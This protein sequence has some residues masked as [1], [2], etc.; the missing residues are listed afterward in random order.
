MR[1]PYEAMTRRKRRIAEVARNGARIVDRKWRRKSRPWRVDG[2][3]RPLLCAHKTVL[4]RE[5]RGDGPPGRITGCIDRIELGRVV[6]ARGIDDGHRAI[7]RTQ[8]RVDRVAL[9]VAAKA[10]GS[11]SLGIQG[12]RRGE[13]WPIAR[14]SAASRLQRCC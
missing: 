13:M 6:I 10:S 1:N 2:G 9:C 8:K 5:V 7:G 4:G 11:R 3:K 14:E 12:D